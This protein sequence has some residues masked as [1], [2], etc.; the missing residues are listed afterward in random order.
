[1][2]RRGID[3]SQTKTTPE[4]STSDSAKNR[5]SSGIVWT[6]Y[7]HPLYPGDQALEV[8]ERCGL[9]LLDDRIN[10]VTVRGGKR[11][12][13]GQLLGRPL[14]VLG[15]RRGVFPEVSVQ[16]HHVVY[17]EPRALDIRQAPGG[18]VRNSMKGN[19]CSASFSDSSIAAVSATERRSCRL[20]R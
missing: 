18:D 14:E 1:M 8:L 7:V 15:S 19:S 2:R 9:R 16:E 12:G 11:Q 13:G 3:L 20:S 6:S 4:W 17:R 5:S 10:V